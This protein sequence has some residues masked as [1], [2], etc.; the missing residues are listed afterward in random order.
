M[1]VY[2]IK[3]THM[4]VFDFVIVN[5][6]TEKKKVVQFRLSEDRNVIESVINRLGDSNP[7]CIVAGYLNGELVEAHR[8]HNIVKDKEL[9][10]KGEMMVIDFIL[11]W[12][13]SLSGE[14]VLPDFSLP[15]RKV[16]EEV[17]KTAR[18]RKPKPH[19]AKFHGVQPQAA[20]I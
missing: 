19:R 11:K 5:F 7:N 9:V 16:K 18:G 12:K 20:G 1:T 15:E 6:F 14:Q 4:K 10:Q 3:H 8:P 13:V 17:I 2:S